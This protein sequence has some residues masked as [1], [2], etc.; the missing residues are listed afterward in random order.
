LDIE[1]VRNICCSKD[2]ITVTSEAAR[3]CNT[4]KMV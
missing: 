2:T 3:I 4:Q 1:E